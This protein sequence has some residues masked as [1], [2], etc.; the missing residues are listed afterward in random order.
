MY[1]MRLKCIRYVCLPNRAPTNC[2]YTQLYLLHSIY[3][4]QWS[5]TWR[6]IKQKLTCF[7]Y[8]GTY[9]KTSHFLKSTLWLG[10]FPKSQE[11]SRCNHVSLIYWEDTNPRVAG[12]MINIAESIAD[13]GQGGQTAIGQQCM[14]CYLTTCARRIANLPACSYYYSN[15][16]EVRECSVLA[17]LSIHPMLC[18]HRV[19][20]F[21]AIDLPTASIPLTGTCTVGPLSIQSPWAGKRMST[22]ALDALN[23]LL[24]V[25][26]KIWKNGWVPVV[27]TSH[28]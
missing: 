20:I 17:D 8:Q 22:G 26:T 12:P 18:Q 6:R 14:K 27:N 4:V 3:H 24:I 25:L 16:H 9:G 23:D 19:K 15:S 5:A 1:W 2:V 21:S 28:L 7:H 10:T 13:A 11:C